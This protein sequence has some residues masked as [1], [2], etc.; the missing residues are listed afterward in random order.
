MNVLTLGIHRT[1]CQTDTHVRKMQGEGISRTRLGCDGICLVCERDARQDL[2]PPMQTAIH[3][4][5]EVSRLLDALLELPPEHQEQKLTELARDQPLLV[6]RARSIMN[7]VDTRSTWLR[8]RAATL[9]DTPM[10]TLAPGQLIGAW[11]VESVL[12]AGG[13][14][15]VY[16]VEREAGGFTQR[17]ALKLVQMS[18]PAEF[19]RF[20]QERQVL[21]QFD[22]PAIAR[23]IDGGTTPAHQPYLVMERIDGGTIDAWCQSQGLSDRAR[24]ELLLPVLDAVAA[25]HA[26]LI[27]HR[28][29]KPSNVLVTPSGRARLIDFGVAQVLGK[30]ENFEDA[31]HSPVSAPYAAPELFTT[32]APTVA[33]DIYGAG[34]L[35]YELLSGR[36]PRDLSGLPVSIAVARSLTMKVVPLIERR[37]PDTRG[38]SA[39]REDLSAIIAQ[40]M[41]TAPEARYTSMNAMIDDLNRALAGLPVAARKA[42]PIYRWRRIARYYRWP[43]AGLTAF[44]L[45]VVA[46]TSAVAWQAR[47]AAR[48]RD[49]AIA[50]QARTESIKQWMYLLLRESSDPN[51][52]ANLRAGILKRAAQRVQDRFATDPQGS[53][54]LL[55]ALGDLYLQTGNYV[56]AEPLLSRVVKAPSP[57]APAPLATAHYDYAQVL[58]RVGKPSEAAAQ[59][60]AARAFWQTDAGRWRSELA[61]SLL[62]EAQIRRPTAPQEALALTREALAAQRLASGPNSRETAVTYNALGVAESAQRNFSE[63]RA[64]L[65]K[66]RDAWQALDLSQSPDALNT[67]NNLAAVEALSGRPEA[68]LPVFQ[69]A[70]ALRRQLFGASAATA[71]LINNMAKILLQLGKAEEALPLASEAVSMARQFT[72]NDS[73][74]SLAAQ[75]GLVDAQLASGDTELA[76][77][78]ALA[79]LAA[80]GDRVTPPRVALRI[81][82]IR[83]QIK[84]KQMR[85]ALRQLAIAEQEAASL[86]PSAAPFSKPLVDLQALL[87]A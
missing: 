55:A 29:L 68:A 41:Q 60:N 51:L 23:V 80:A 64:A 62:V 38:G 84:A 6:A 31:A 72:G 47:E 53:A 20:E 44:T 30:A 25:A 32:A 10:P 73:A 85:D 59:L 26:V 37:A 61:A 22:H 17:A 34:A 77:R 15:T 21:A 2:K 63:A 19:A 49:A 87:R 16:A 83:A 78:T 76:V 75:A 27:L 11:R 50:E 9:I 13:M 81:A 7:W 1:G 56:E 35:L 74:L 3:D 52:N 8:P 48:A 58:V 12:G 86:G 79:A 40:A 42:E 82:L 71:A 14:G 70:V 36:P 66:A 5:P 65:Q 39:L 54:P 28:D 69:E 45:L 33:I 43:L 4:W 67:L 18:G 57:L 46:G 24:V